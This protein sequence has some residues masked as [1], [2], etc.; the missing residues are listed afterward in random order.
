MGEA[1]MMRGELEQIFDRYG[2]MVLRRAKAILGNEEEAKDAT[3]EVFIRAFLNADKFEHRSHVTTWLY[4]ITT[5]VCLNWI[6]DSKRRREL[7][8]EHCADEP[9][10]F[11]PT[12]DRRVLARTLLAEA[13]E[14]WAQAAIYVHIDGMSHHEAAKMLGVS[15]RTVGNLLARFERF[16][17]AQLERHAEEFDP[18]LTPTPTFLGIQ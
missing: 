17:H 4:R 10:A 2:P 16:A 3:Q 12:N 7:D 8:L 18:I 14:A 6:R 1:A 9:Y 11:M 15:R 5:N 13:D